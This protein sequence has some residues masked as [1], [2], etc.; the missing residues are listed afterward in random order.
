MKTRIFALV[1][2]NNFY[3]SCE[4]VFRPDLKGKP[5]IVLSNN[6]GCAVARSNEVKSLGIPMGTPAFKIADLIKKHN[7]QIYSSNYALYGDMSERVMN[8][9]ASF[10]SNIEI[11]SIDEA[12][13][14]LSDIPETQITDFCKKVR[15]TVY[16]WTG[17]PVSVGIAETKTLAKIANRIAK[18]S[19]KAKGLLDLTRSPYINHALE[20]TDVEDVW[21][22]GRQYG[23]FLK[24]HGILN[25]LQLRDAAKN[26]IRKKMGIC[27]TKMQNELK[28]QSCFPL[29]TNPPAKKG[30]SVS[31]TFKKAVTAVEDI[32]EAI[33]TF[34]SIGGEKLRRERSVA[35]LMI[36]YISTGRF[37]D[38]T[39]YASKV[40]SLPVPTNS[41]PELIRYAGDAIEKIF[42]KDYLLKKVG[43][44]FQELSPENSY[45]TGLFDNFDREKSKKIMTSLDAINKKMGANTLKYA[46][47]GLDASPKWRTV[48]NMRSPAYTTDWN[49]LACVL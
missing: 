19:K 15:K 31:R 14:D 26:L 30:I 33:A 5:V 23:K 29:E 36:I 18:K 45:Q 35:K 32:K 34:I 27:G 46:A 17:I 25:A 1:D 22:V 41:T 43:V 38:H 12:F 42:R 16:K 11:Y 6:D 49:Q 9:L 24:N 3:V 48:F 7:I 2:C 20:I 44:I 4:R 37:V 40:V 13:L 21:G 28:G 8:T 47:T 10:E 39:Y